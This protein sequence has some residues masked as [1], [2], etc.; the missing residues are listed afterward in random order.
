[1]APPST[2]RAPAAAGKRTRDAG[3]EGAP[4]DGRGRADKRPRNGTGGDPDQFSPARTSTDDAD[5]SAGG[6]GTPGASA[7]APLLSG[8]PLTQAQTNEAP[9]HAVQHAGGGAGGAGGAGGSGAAGAA[10]AAAALLGA[11][12]PAQNALNFDPAP[13]WTFPAARIAA[14]KALCANVRAALRHAQPCGCH[15]GNSGSDASKVHACAAAPPGG[16]KYTITLPDIFTS[17]GAAIFTKEVLRLRGRRVL[18]RHTTE[19]E[20]YAV[21]A[22]LL[23][24]QETLVKVGLLASMSAGLRLQRAPAPRR[25]ESGPP[26]PLAA[27]A[28]AG[29]GPV[30]GT[31]GANASGGA[32]DDDDDD[33]AQ[34]PDDDDDGDGAAAGAAA[35]ATAAAMMLTAQTAAAAAAK[36]AALP[37]RARALRIGDRGGMVSAVRAQGGG[38]EARIRGAALPNRGASIARCNIDSSAAAAAATQQQNKIA[39]R[40]AAAARVPE[41]DVIV[42]SSDD[43]EADV[44]AAAAGPVPEKRQLRTRKPPLVKPKAAAPPPLPRKQQQRQQQQQQ[45]AAAPPPALAATPPPAVAEAVPAAAAAVAQQLPAASA[46]PRARARSK[47]VPRRRGSAA[48]AAAAPE[49]EP[50]AAAI[51]AIASSPSAAT[52]PQVVAAAAPAAQAAPPAPAVPEPAPPPAAEDN[53]IDLTQD[54]DDD[55]DDGIMLNTNQ[56]ADAAPAA[57]A[58]PPAAAIVVAA[59]ALAP[60]PVPPPPPPPPPA[61]AAAASAARAYQAG[62]TDGLS[63]G[64]EL[65][66]ILSS[67][68][69]RFGKLTIA[70]GERLKELALAGDGGVHAA[71]AVFFADRDMD[72]LYDGLCERLDAL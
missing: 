68:A 56:L 65:A 1:M 36:Q 13:T 44:A 40:S 37:P 61:L 64:M 17:E 3:G 20:A 10:G 60:P 69:G 23:D 72:A 7:P 9:A 6:S 2:N 18:S 34:A 27:G 29:A 67:N 32:H 15:D 51:V 8:T 12:P 26:L 48:A 19:E 42:I 52:I 41:E 11:A 47:A 71:F 21:Q 25:D 62:M 49:P 16:P 24:A 58:P 59:A 66:V 54:D 33:G 39:Q 46:P 70:R 53:C 14:A 43:D 57:A 50:E 38:G 4:S 31:S 55:D 22:K 63:R 35:A 30:A 28:N 45:Q 5:E